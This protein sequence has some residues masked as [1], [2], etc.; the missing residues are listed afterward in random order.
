MFV[1][2]SWLTN[3][4]YRVS[5]AEITTNWD[6]RNGIHEL[7]FLQALIFSSSSYS[8][9]LTLSTASSPKFSRSFSSALA[10][11]RLRLLPSLLPRRMLRWMPILLHFSPTSIPLCFLILLTWLLSMTTFFSALPCCVREDQR[12]TSISSR[13]EEDV[14]VSAP[15]RLPLFK[16][17][18]LWTFLCYSRMLLERT[19]VKFIGVFVMGVWS[20]EYQDHLEL[21]YVIILVIYPKSHQDSLCIDSDSCDLK[22][23]ILEFYWFLLFQKYR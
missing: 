20:V 12:W 15:A 14:S 16:S 19:P 4:I 8:P 22:I 23:N 18:C 21:Q 3:G 9:L 10:P 1:H 5:Y 2:L 13:R 11:L 7:R 17:F 6:L